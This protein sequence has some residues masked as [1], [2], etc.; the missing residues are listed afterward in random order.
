MFQAT[1]SSSRRRIKRRRYRSRLRPRLYSVNPSFS[2][3]HRGAPYLRPYSVA[4]RVVPTPT[5]SR[6]TPAKRGTAALRARSSQSKQSFLKKKARRVNMAAVTEKNKLKPKVLFSTPVA[7]DALPSPLESANMAAGYGSHGGDFMEDARQDS[8]KRTDKS[9]R[10]G[11]LKGSKKKSGKSDSSLW[12]T[13]QQVINH[14]LL[15]MEQ[16]NKVDPDL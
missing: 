7:T 9:H 2:G 6:R 4:R 5:R 14:D 3:V 1:Y 16:N 11:Q 12:N 15:R 8:L 10:E 13:F